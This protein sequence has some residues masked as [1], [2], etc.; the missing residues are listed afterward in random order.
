MWAQ[1]CSVR[2]ISFAVFR[3]AEICWYR[4]SNKLFCNFCV[5]YIQSYPAIICS[6][7]LMKATYFC[8]VDPIHKLYKSL[9]RLSTKRKVVRIPCKLQTSMMA[10]IA[11]YDHM[12]LR[13][14]FNDDIYTVPF[15]SITLVN[16]F[17]VGLSWL[18]FYH[19]FGNIKSLIFIKQSHMFCF[20][21]YE[22][23]EGDIDGLN[24]LETY[25][26]QVV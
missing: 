4:Y 26:I 6:T 3:R 18:E 2:S 24:Q 11:S 12:L 1:L 19:N 5:S 9:K 17:I 7:L 8:I 23:L 10:D 22:H 13:I 21:S 16:T 14:K 25:L 15:G 20:P